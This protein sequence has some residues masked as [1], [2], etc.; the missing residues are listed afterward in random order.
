MRASKQGCLK[1]LN[2][3]NWSLRD[4]YTYI[5]VYI[6]IFLSKWKVGLVPKAEANAER[7]AAAKESQKQRVRVPSP[8]GLRIFPFLLCIP[9]V[10]TRNPFRSTETSHHGNK[11]IR[12]VGT[13]TKIMLI[14]GLLGAK[15]ISSIHSITEHVLLEGPCHHE[16]ASKNPRRRKHPGGWGAGSRCSLPCPCGT[17]HLGT[18]PESTW[19]GAR[20]M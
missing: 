19:P 2:Q 17:G 5:H 6:Y 16:R 7:H 12:F 1:A 15:W 9:T 3:S 10:V 18:S 20:T 11:N 14:R 13:S 8:S 4:T